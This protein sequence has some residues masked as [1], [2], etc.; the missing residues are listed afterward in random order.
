[1]RVGDSEDGARSNEGGDPISAALAGDEAGFERVHDRYGQGLIRFFLK[2]VTGRIDLAEE[3]SQKTWVLVWRA[4][5]AQNGLTSPYLSPEWA[6]MVGAERPDARVAVLSEHGTIKGFLGVQRRSRF[7]AMGL[8]A[9]IADYQGLVGAPDLAVR[10]GEICRA[11]KVG[12]L[13]L[14]HVPAGQGFFA[15][16]EAVRDGSWIAETGGSGEAYRAG[17]KARRAEFVRQTDKK[18][19][20]MGKERGEAVF[21]ANSTSRAH[22]GQMLGWKRMQLLRS[23]QPDI[24]TTPWVARV[25]DGTFT[26]ETPGCRGALFTLT[27]GDTLVAANYFLRSEGVLHDWIIA[28]NPAFEAYSPGVA[29]AR[30]AIEW[31]GDN[32]IAEVDFGPGGY[33]YK[34]QLATG[35]RELTWGSAGG[36]SLSGVARRAAYAARV[37]LERAPQKLVAELPGKAM[38][39]I[40]LMRGLAAPAG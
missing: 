28:H 39:R 23:G 16:Y 11:L 6:Q 38:R 32:G 34:R 37:Q 15:P 9:P 25:L 24:W 29:L 14:D 19:R 33:Q 31:A 27:V 22:F 10:A 18:I 30:W 20:K 21:T 3:L 5:Q 1:M 40:D 2:R 4:L 17:L 35:Q 13:D 26:R 7:A 36:L 12:R 8:G